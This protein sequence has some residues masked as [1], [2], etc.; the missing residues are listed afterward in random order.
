MPRPVV[1]NAEHQITVRVSGIQR[2]RLDETADVL[3]VSRSAIARAL[4]EECLDDPRIRERI[5]VETEGGMIP[6]IPSELVPVPRPD[7]N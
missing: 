5:K 7:F 2:D 6:A 4:I 3:G 1:I